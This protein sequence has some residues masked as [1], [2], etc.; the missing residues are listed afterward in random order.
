MYNARIFLSHVSQL[1]HDSRTLLLCDLDDKHLAMSSGPLIIKLGKKKRHQ[2]LSILVFIS[3]VMLR[4]SRRRE[5]GCTQL[6]RFKRLFGLGRNACQM[7]TLSL[8]SSQM[9]P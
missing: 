7:A 9:E 6:H 1:T 5:S 2:L 4:E 8:N 3:I